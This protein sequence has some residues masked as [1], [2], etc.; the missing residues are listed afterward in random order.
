MRIRRPERD[1]A[2]HDGD[3]RGRKQ[4]RAFTLEGDTPARDR[5]AEYHL[6]PP[7]GIV[8]R[9][10]AYLGYGKDSQHQRH[11]REPEDADNGAVEITLTAYIGTED[12][13]VADEIGH[14]FRE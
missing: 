14:R 8:G 4:Q 1:D 6:Q 3:Q 2:P 11:H 9:P 7:L 5:C 12:R 13:D 10:A